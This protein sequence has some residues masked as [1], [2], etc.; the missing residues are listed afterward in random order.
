MKGFWRCSLIVA[1]TLSATAWGQQKPRTNARP[2]LSGVWTYSIDLPAR[3]L[4][5]VIDGQTIIQAPDRSGRL[6]AR[7]EVSGAI[8]GWTA[9]PVYKPELEAKVKETYENQ[10]KTD[11]T[12]LCGRPG[13]PRLGPP[14]KIIQ[15]PDEMIFLYEEMSGDTYR[16]IPTN[17]RKHNP[18]LDPSYNGDAIGRWEG[19]VL[20]VESVNF[21]KNT[22]FGELGYFHSD[23]L[24][25]T[26]RF[27]REGENL[28]YQ[29][30]VDDPK[31]LSQPWI[32]APRLIKP[33]TEP[34][35]ETPDCV[36]DD[37]H[38]L[39]NNDHHTQR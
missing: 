22:W 18:D 14:R 26:E 33:T 30:I 31:V 10:T 21:V 4:K 23:A 3:A 37:A 8:Q 39:T 6:P 19:D 34:L 16:V 11:N 38:R 17:G 25:V 32:Q 29:V 9:A 1:L 13:V 2:D 28:A 27:W 20:V 35:L 24:K 5:Q 7:E 12:F 36:D 15:L